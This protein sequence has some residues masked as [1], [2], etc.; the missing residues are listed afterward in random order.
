MDSLTSPTV[1]DGPRSFEHACVSVCVYVYVCSRASN[2]A[3]RKPFSDFPIKIESTVV[4]LMYALLLRRYR[5][6][7][8]FQ[9]GVSAAKRQQLFD[10]LRR[11]VARACSR[12][13]TYVHPPACARTRI[14]VYTLLYKSCIFH[15]FP[16]DRVPDRATTSLHDG[17]AYIARTTYTQPRTSGCIRTYAFLSEY[18]SPRGDIATVAAE[19]RQSKHVIDIV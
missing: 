18:I 9:P 5:A 2:S 6:N 19:R 12:K 4:N 13:H 16:G 7:V 8:I 1:R 15:E 14:R 10:R 11:T 3:R 17:R